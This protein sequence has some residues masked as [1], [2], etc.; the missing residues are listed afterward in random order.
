MIR[1]EIDAAPVLF[2]FVETFILFIKN[3]SRLL[4][5]TQTLN[6]GFLNM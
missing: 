6:F 3:R 5:E 4:Y 2:D 1:Y